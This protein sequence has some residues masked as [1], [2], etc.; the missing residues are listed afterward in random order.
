[1]RRDKRTLHVVLPT[2]V[3]LRDAMDKAMA[4]ITLDDIANAAGCSVNTL[5]QSRLK[6]DNAGYRSPPASLRRALFELCRERA[7]Y[8]IELAEEL[9]PPKG[10]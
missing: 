1:M 9:R 8:F 10:P 7:K 2:G 6:P 5:K 4:R 3:D